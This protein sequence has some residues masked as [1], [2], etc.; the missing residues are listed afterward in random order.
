MIKATRHSDP[1]LQVVSTKRLI[2]IL[3]LRKCE[4][5]RP[6]IFL[7]N[8][9]GECQITQQGTQ[10]SLASVFLVRNTQGCPRQVCAGKICR[11]WVGRSESGKEGV[12]FENLS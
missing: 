3:S 6:I 2:I 10:N 7:D 11:S 5:M 1:V 12:A 4:M 9:K 8:K